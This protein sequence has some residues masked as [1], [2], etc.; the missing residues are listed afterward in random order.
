MMRQSNLVVV[1]AELA[2]PEVGNETRT[3]R[4]TAPRCLFHP[5]VALDADPQ[6][7]QLL[8]DSLFF[9]LLP[10]LLL[11]Y[12]PEGSSSPLPFRPH[13]CLSDSNC[14]L[15]ALDFFLLGLVSCHFSARALAATS[16]AR[17]LAAT[18]LNSASHFFF[19]SIAVLSASIVLSASNCLHTALEIP[20]S[21]CVPFP[22]WTRGVFRAG[23][24]IALD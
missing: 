13:L 14:L 11:T 21:R 22:G 9:A 16:T 17:C 19:S 2:Q 20:G 4:T 15:L 8:Q 7:P 1:Y 3:A 12:L 10:P 23:H 18:L 5:L 6:V 24:R